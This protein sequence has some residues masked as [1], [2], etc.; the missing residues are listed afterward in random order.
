MRYMDA[1]VEPA[2][3][4]LMDEKEFKSSMFQRPFQYLQR[5]NTG[6]ELRNIQCKRVMGTPEQCIEVLLRL[7]LHAILSVDDIHSSI[8]AGIDACFN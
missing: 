4:Q 3:D 2:H 6:Q 1:V 5:F 8:L 7:V